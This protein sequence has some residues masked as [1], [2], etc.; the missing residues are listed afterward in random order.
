MEMMKRALFSCLLIFL[1]LLSSLS[2]AQRE[3][4]TKLFVYCAAAISQPML[5]L[6]KEFEKRYNI[7]IEYTFAGSPCLLSQIIFTKSGDLY[8]PGEQWYIDQAIDKGLIHSWKVVALFVPVIAVQKG[9][10]KGVNSILDFLRTDVKV[11]LGNKDACA[12][13]HI[14]DKI[15]KKAEKMLKRNGIAEGI[16][17]KT[18]YMAMQ[19]PELGNSIKLKQLDATIIWNATAHRIRDSIDVIPIDP[20]YRIDSP[21]PLGIL[22]F[23]KHIEEAEKFLNF[24]SSPEGKRIFLKHGFGA[25]DNNDKK[26]NESLSRR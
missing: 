17:K 20:K 3:K 8:M 22:K 25:L 15:F 24:V 7:K 23:S 5:E 16:W 1:V 18:A 26:K 4:G 12:I 10:P 21:I 9:N 6:G 2:F 13:G 11:G 19:E 14:S